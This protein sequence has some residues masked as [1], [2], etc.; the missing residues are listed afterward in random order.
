MRAHLNHLVQSHYTCVIALILMFLFLVYTT[1]NIFLCAD[2]TFEMMLR[3]GS[4]PDTSVNGRVY[5]FQLP[6][7]P[8]VEYYIHTFTNAYANWENHKLVE[9]VMANV[10]LSKVV[11]QLQQQQPH[12]QFGEV[13]L[14]GVSSVPV[15]PPLTKTSASRSRSS[16]TAPAPAP[17]PQPPKISAPTS[18]AA[19]AI[20]SASHSPASVTIRQI[21]SAQMKQVEERLARQNAAAV[22]AISTTQASATSQ[23]SPT[24]TSAASPAQA[25]VNPPAMS[26]SLIQESPQQAAQQNAALLL[27]L[28][29]Q[30]KQFSRMMIPVSCIH[31]SH[32]S[33]GA[34]A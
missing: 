34:T 10:D 8:A 24:S 19:S 3:W 20:P 12:K 1:L 7:L 33:R 2:G 14:T 17:A 5:E 9:D 11:L 23:V 18:V 27:A 22:A 31:A 28:Q 21:N 29:Q 26:P 25:N 4:Q 32:F 6:N 13:N 30:A 15:P 16:V